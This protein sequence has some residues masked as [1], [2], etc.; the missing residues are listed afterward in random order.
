MVHYLKKMSK[1][2]F[3]SSPL[4]AVDTGSKRRRG[5]NTQKQQ[6]ALTDTVS[7]HKQNVFAPP[8]SRVCP[9]LVCVFVHGCPIRPLCSF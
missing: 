3:Y 7:S 1:T 5:R 4:Q 6:A 2:M 9:A 8:D